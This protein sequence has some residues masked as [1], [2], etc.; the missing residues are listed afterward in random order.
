MSSALLE[1][2]GLGSFDIAYIFIGMAVVILIL[3]ILIILVSVMLVFTMTRETSNQE[4]I[5]MEIYK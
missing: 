5:L 2:M 1:S 3:L 4:I